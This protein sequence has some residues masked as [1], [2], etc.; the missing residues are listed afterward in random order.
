MT[1]DVSKHARLGIACRFLNILRL[2]QTQPLAQKPISALLVGNAIVWSKHHAKR[3][4]HLPFSSSWA[5]RMNL[6][7]VLFARSGSMFAMAIEVASNCRLMT[8]K[9]CSLAAM[10]RLLDQNS[11][12]WVAAK[13]V[14]ITRHVPA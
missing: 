14:D 10:V 1:S 6:E 11:P 3:S 5:A 13:P 4:L 2:N 7:L 8:P 12:L 9:L